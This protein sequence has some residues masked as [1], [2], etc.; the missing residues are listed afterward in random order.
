MKTIVYPN[1]EELSI[2]TATQIAKIIAGK[3]DA[4]VCFP[5]GETPLG[6]F[7]RLVEMNRTG[8]VTFEQCRIVGLDEW[9]Q[10]GTMTH[11]NCRHYLAKHLLDRINIKSENICFFNGEAENLQYECSL[12]D[13]FIEAN[14]GID[15]MLLGVGMNGHIALNEPGT[16]FDTLSHVVELDEATKRFGQ[17]YFSTRA[18]LSRGIT[19]GMKHVM[20]ARTL[21]VQMSGSG[22]APIAHRLLENEVTEEFPVS[23]VKQHSNAFLLLDS[24]ASSGM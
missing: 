19:L 21:I 20:E 24:D 8:L 3:V 23:I 1:Y 22:K 2:G 18:A 15:I 5:A 7:A 12:S 16:S 10:L 13:R 14:G 6:T 11:E 9:V 4:L 17:K